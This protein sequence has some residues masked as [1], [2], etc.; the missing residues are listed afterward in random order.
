MAIRV[1]T[2][3]DINFGNAGAAVSVTHIRLREDD[4][5]LPIVKQLP[6]PIQIAPGAP[7]RIPSGLY[8]LVYP[9][10]DMGNAHMLDILRPYWTNRAMEVDLMT[11]A[12]TPV[13]VAGYAQQP[14]SNWSISQEAD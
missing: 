5:S 2:Q 9:A 4:D 6:N 11:D 3:A 8:D 1:Q 7:M 10:G 12:N 13:A 14:Y